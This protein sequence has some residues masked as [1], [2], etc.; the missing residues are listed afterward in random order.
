MPSYQDDG[1]S[2]PVSNPI[3]EVEDRRSVLG[4]VGGGSAVGVAKSWQHLQGTLDTVRSVVPVHSHSASDGPAVV[5]SSAFEDA[6]HL[7]TSCEPDPGR[8]E[9][10]GK[11]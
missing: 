4:T 10:L 1:D 5:A 9:A 7:T 8:T 6:A 11:S 2:G 3:V